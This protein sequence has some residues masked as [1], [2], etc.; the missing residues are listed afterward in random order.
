MRIAHL[1]RTLFQ[2]VPDSFSFL[3]L[4]P[5]HTHI[6]T[7]MSS[8][9]P[10]MPANTTT[11]TTTQTPLSF[12]DLP[13]DLQDEVESYNCPMQVFLEQVRNI[14][15]CCVSVASIKEWMG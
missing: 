9:P 2:A 13:W 12:C 6:Q 10:P 3:L 15:E 11:T 5:H 1:F 14:S 8:A 4:S 7:G